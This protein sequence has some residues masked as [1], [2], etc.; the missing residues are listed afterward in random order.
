MITDK[1]KA[2]FQFVEFLHSNIDNFK[3]YDE[4]INELHLL[5]KKKNELSPRK[6]FK[7][8]LKFDEV[9]AEIKNKFKVI[10]ENITKPIQTKVTELNIC[11]LNQIDT[12]LNWY[13]TEIGNLEKNFNNNDIPE[14]LKHK[15]QYIEYR[16]ETKGETFFGLDL[17]FNYL[18]ETLKKLFN[19][20][21]ETEQNEFEAFETK[22]I[23][24]NDISEANKLI[25]KGHEKF[26]MPFSFLNP[27]KV[28]Q[29]S[30]FETLPPQ[31]M[32]KQ[33]MELPERLEQ[34]FEF[35]SK[36]KKVMEI[37]V[38]KELIYPNTY[39]RN[40]KKCH[41][42]FLCALLKDMKG[43]GYYKDEITVNYEIC[44]EI[45]KNTFKTKIESNK[46]FYTELAPNEK[47]IIPFATTMK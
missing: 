35:T 15:N 47:N 29:Q 19:C 24:V 20:F 8:K 40:E 13:I 22:A 3:Q 21:K 1:I 2:L 17:F 26:A 5:I 32:P 31:P 41:K 9:Q 37:L 12:L 39:I 11:D 36:Y 4:V 10:Q 30:N 34:L 18:D 45:C 28:Q 42:G 33:K 43:K 27:S 23:Q 16:T 14:I 46:T 44:K 6:N 25:Q 7:D 38:S